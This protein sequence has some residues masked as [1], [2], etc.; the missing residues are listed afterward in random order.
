MDE[1][2]ATASRLV[3][4]DLI[5]GL[6]ILGV[7]L[8]H[9]VWDLDLYGYLPGGL[10]SHPVWIA[11]GRILATAFMVLVG[12]GIVLAHNQGFRM[13]AFARRVFIIALAA[14]VVSVATLLAF[15]HAF[16]YFGILHA[17]VAASVLGALLLRL[18]AATLAQ[19]G[20]FVVLLGLMASFDTFNSRWLAWIGFSSDTPQSL[21]FVPLFPW[22]GATLFGMAGAKCGVPHILEKGL[23]NARKMRLVRALMLAGRES[24]AI[25]L[26]HQPLLLGSIELTRRLTS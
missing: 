3:V 12:V 10:A 7:V 22:F 4:V 19:L 9:L 26:I 1:R 21:D 25:Y 11:F 15:P 20:V 5:R 14:M 2:T 17:I 8:F 16:V 18:D 24:L 23:Y 13:R 6:A